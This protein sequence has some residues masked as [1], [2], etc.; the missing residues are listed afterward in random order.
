M[1]HEWLRRRATK[2]KDYDSSNL[3]NTDLRG[4][5]S[6]LTTG[7]DDCVLQWIWDS[8]CDQNAQHPSKYANSPKIFENGESMMEGSVNG[9]W[10]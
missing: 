1:V 3:A 4:P 8:Q 5:N 10:W 6:F 2:T 7:E 9:S